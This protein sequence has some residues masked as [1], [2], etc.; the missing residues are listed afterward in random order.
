[1]E[2]CVPACSTGVCM[3]LHSS[4]CAVVHLYL[5][6]VCAHVQVCTLQRARSGEQFVHVCIRTLC[7]VQGACG[8]C[9]KESVC[10]CTCV[11]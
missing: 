10:G 2:S 9:Q 7:H 6:A 4:V 8:F 1:M 3:Y 5:D 11:L